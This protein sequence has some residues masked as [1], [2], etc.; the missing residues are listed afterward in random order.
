M[1]AA[2]LVARARDVGVRLFVEAG[3]IKAEP[4][5]KLPPELRTAIQAGKAAIVAILEREDA[6]AGCGRRDWSISLVDDV[7]NRTCLDCA[8]GRTALR[9]NGVAI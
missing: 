8:T 2:D 5:G 4:A 9:R 1:T 6:C 7:G 3:R